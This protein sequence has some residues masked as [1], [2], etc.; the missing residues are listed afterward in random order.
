MCKSGQHSQDSYNIPVSVDIFIHKR[1]CFGIN[2]RNIF[3][4]TV[5]ETNS[6]NYS[7][8]GRDQILY[9]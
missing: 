9:E 6:G 8:N 5:K 1:S 7:Q 4:I 3:I 2:I